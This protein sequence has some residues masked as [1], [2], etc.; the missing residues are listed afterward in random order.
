[1]RPPLPE[2]YRKK[3]SSTVKYTTCKSGGSGSHDCSGMHMQAAASLQGVTACWALP[4]GRP[5]CQC[6]LQLAP[7][8]SGDG[9]RPR[10]VLH[11]HSPLSTQGRGRGRREVALQAGGHTHHRSPRQSVQQRQVV[12]RH[13]LIAGGRAQGQGTVSGGSRCLAAAVV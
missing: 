5:Q 4:A 2:S 3:L 12:S 9:L 10:L 13:A 1:M 11:Q 6:I 8:T 7:W